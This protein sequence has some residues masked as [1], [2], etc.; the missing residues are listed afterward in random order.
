MEQNKPTRRSTER[1]TARLFRGRPSL[2]RSQTCQH[3]TAVPVDRRWPPRWL[4]KVFWLLYSSSQ[5]WKITLCKYY[6]VHSAVRTGVDILLYRRSW[7]SQQGMVAG[8][9][10]HGSILS[11]GNFYANGIHRDGWYQCSIV[12]WNLGLQCFL[13]ETSKIVIWILGW[14]IQKTEKANKTVHRTIHSSDLSR[15]AQFS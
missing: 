4:T 8:F 13:R 1:S 3:H 6:V 9:D 12:F 15:K 5:L 10:K 7:I 11:G 2:A 14:Y